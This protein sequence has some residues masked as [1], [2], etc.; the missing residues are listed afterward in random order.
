MTPSR[1]DEVRLAVMLLSRLPAGQIRGEPP[2]MAASFWA[3]PL[4]GIAV[5][6]LGSVV[7]WLAL[8]IGAPPTIAALLAVTAGV[9]ATGA[10]HEDGLADLADGFGGG[11]DRERKLEIMRDSRI[12]SYGVIALLLAFGLRWVGLSVAAGTGGATLALIGLAA[13]SRAVLPAALVL[14][15]AAR[16]DGLG[17]AARGDD[18]RPALAA[19]GLGFFCL[20]PLGLGTALTV[21]IVVAIASLAVAVLALRQIGGQTG[22]V[23]GAMQQVAE[24]AGWVILASAL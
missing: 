14:M 15:P 4:V 11:R 6:A 24:C 12:G 13:A 1:S 8:G 5:G 3:W 22:D 9:L 7:C 23:M 21:A 10:M 16:S 17:Y 18:M 19:A 20:M 2:A